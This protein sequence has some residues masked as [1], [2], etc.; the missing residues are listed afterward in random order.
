[1]EKPLLTETS[2]VLMYGDRVRFLWKDST[3]ECTLEGLYAGPNKNDPK[4][5]VVTVVTPGQYRGEVIYPYIWSLNRIEHPE[6]VKKNVAEK[7]YDRRTLELMRDNILENFQF[8]RVHIAMLALEWEWWDCGIP[9]IE[10]LANEGKRLLDTVIEEHIATGRNRC[11]ISTG[12]FQAS[13]E[14]CEDDG[15]PDLSLQFMVDEWYEGGDCWKEYE[16]DFDNRN[17]KK[18]KR[19][20]KPKRNAED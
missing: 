18:R 10:I 8:D 4:E 1:M 11:I 14:I 12:G 16:K 5:A 13:L 3:G 17:N 20:R 19:K 7:K 6:I 2:E 9:S 15:I